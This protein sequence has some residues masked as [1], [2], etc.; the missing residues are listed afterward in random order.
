MRA[1]TVSAFWRAVAP[2]LTGFKLELC[3][4]RDTNMYSRSSYTLCGGHSM[5]QH[6]MEILRRARLPTDTLDRSCRQYVALLRS[7]CERLRS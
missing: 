6:R 1:D 2:E 7:P 5:G 3:H 4:W